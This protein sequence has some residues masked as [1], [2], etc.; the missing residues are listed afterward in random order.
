ML[1]IRLFVSV[2]LGVAA[3]SAA[4]AQSNR[5]RRADSVVA[6]AR[7][8]IG[9]LRDTSSL[10]EA[11]WHAIG[12]GGGVRDLSP[13]QGQHWVLGM[14]FSLNPPVALSQPTFL[15]FLPMGDSL[16]PIGVAYTRRISVDAPLPDSLAGG[17]AEWHTHML[18]R[19]APNQVAMIH[20]WTIP[21]PD[22]P[23]AHDNPA[24]PYLATGLR[25]P[26]S[27]SRDARLLGVALG[28]TYGAKLFIAHRIEREVRRRNLSPSGVAKLEELRASMRALVPQLRSAQRTGDTRKFSALS[29]RLIESWNA[30]AAQYLALAPTPEMKARFDHELAKAL[31]RPHSHM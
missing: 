27:G 18:C 24:L 6:E 16:V 10:Q 19:P 31:D 12:F 28:E 11:G 3:T 23:Y 25:A 21:N 29:K 13:F 22:G 30:L 9:T 4:A 5:D 26:R 15:M 14:R 20:A 2:A 1:P 7:R 17:A 8:A